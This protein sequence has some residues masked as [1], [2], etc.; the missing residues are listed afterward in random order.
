MFECALHDGCARQHEM[1]Q[2][3][4][5]GA[6]NVEQAHLDVR[7][8]GAVSKSL[9]LVGVHRDPPRDV[10]VI[11][12]PALDLLDIQCGG[13]P[14]SQF[15]PAWQASPCGVPERQLLLF[16]GDEKHRRQLI[17]QCGYLLDVH[18]QLNG[19]RR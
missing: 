11:G 10:A 17:E 4:I 18:R 5:I 2:V 3:F 7:Q 1:F 15:L 12:I 16:E 13:E 9:L 14:V 8:V 6:V 19:L